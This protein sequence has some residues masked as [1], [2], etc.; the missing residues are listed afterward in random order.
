M[1]PIVEEEL[2]RLEKL[3]VLENIDHADCAAPIVVVPKKD[4]HVRICGDYKVTVNQELDVNQYPL[5]H[6]L[7]L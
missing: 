4:G 6:L 7:Q 1:R 2:D 3:R 5:P